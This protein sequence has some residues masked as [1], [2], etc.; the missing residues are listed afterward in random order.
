MCLCVDCATTT[1]SADVD[2]E[3]SP[4]CS[5]E[6]CVPVL[7]TNACLQLVLHV[8]TTEGEPLQSAGHISL[9][10]DNFVLI[11]VTFDYFPLLL[12]ERQSG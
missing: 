5:L 6:R 12:P 10:L 9:S 11:V 3:G 7:C 2:R 1:Q 8:C 4:V